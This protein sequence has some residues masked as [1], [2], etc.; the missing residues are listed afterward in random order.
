[1]RVTHISHTELYRAHARHE[2]EQGYAFLTA[3]VCAII[4]GIVGIVVLGIGIARLAISVP[5][6]RT[7]IPSIDSGIYP[8]A[9]VES[10]EN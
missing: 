5:E 2:T 10:C 1:M 6:E 8:D 3:A 9:H 4:L 7:G